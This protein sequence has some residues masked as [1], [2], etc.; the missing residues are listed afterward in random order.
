[1]FPTPAAPVPIVGQLHR[2]A[3]IVWEDR[4]ATPRVVCEVARRIKAEF[5]Q[6]A[7]GRR[8]QPLASEAAARPRVRIEQ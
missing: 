6:H 4:E 3:A 5:A 1:M 7:Q 8:M 2:L